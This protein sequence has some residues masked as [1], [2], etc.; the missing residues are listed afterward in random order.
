M[1]PEP[2]GERDV[3][4]GTIIASIPAVTTLEARD[5]G[6]IV[7]SASERHFRRA[8]FEVP[9]TRTVWDLSLR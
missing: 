5:D 2:P 6:R 8:G 4:I 9:Y 7:G 3:L 1:A